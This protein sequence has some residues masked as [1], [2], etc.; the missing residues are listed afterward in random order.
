VDSWVAVG[1][2][3]AVALR[4]DA[5]LR[6]ARLV[7]S[8]VARFVAVADSTVAVVFMAEA[9]D[10]VGAVMVADTGKLVRSLI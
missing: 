6:M 8:T 7:G 3:V 5:A 2:R 10:T 1:L 4:V 9:A